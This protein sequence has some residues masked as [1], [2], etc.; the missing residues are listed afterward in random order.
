MRKKGYSD[1]V[2]GL[3]F[4]DEGKARIVDYLAKDYDI[5]ARFNGG[6]NAGHTIENDKGRVALQQI[7]SGIFHKN[8]VLYIG[9]GCNVNIEKL[10]EEIEK[11]S[12]IK[13]DIRK[14]LKI[15]SHASV[16]QPHHIL[17]DEMLGKS[18]GTTKNGIGPSYADKAMRM[19]KGRIVN[20]RMADLLDGEDKFFDCIRKNLTETA[21]QYGIKIKNPQNTINKI[22]TAYRKIKPFIEVNPLYLTKEVEKGR[23]VLFEGAQSVMLDVSKGSIPYVTS[24]ST[25]SGAAYVGGDLPSRYHRKT[26]GIVKAVMSRVGHGPF[27]SEFGGRRSEEYCMAIEDGKIKYPKVKE[28]EYNVEKLIK[29]G[30]DFKVGVALRILSKEY[31]TVTSRPRRI[32]ALDLVQ[33]SHTVKMNGVDEIYINKCDLLCE[34]SRTKEG[35]MPVVVSYTL[36]GKKIN[37]VPVATTALYRVKPGVE[38]RKSVSDNVSGVRKFNQLPQALR[39]FLKEIEKVCNCKIAGVGVGP[40]REQFIRLN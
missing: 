25:V 24:S 34:Y 35:K 16:I 18:V 7:P 33:L 4:G 36:D 21:R 19:Y 31:G 14:R 30:D 22:K 11:L 15:S 9:S 12:E 38:F 3:Q 39:I 23:R 1:V 40:K 10:A 5:I 32:G 29:S 6:A 8:T 26:I 2:L 28:L 27:P 20:I 37:Y 17:L 13:I